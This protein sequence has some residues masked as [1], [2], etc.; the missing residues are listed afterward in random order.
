MTPTIPRTQRSLSIVASLILG[1]LGIVSLNEHLW[2]SLAVLAVG[3][4]LFWT[5][6]AVSLSAWK[7]V[8]KPKDYDGAF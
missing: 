8:R 1:Y 3:S 5:T 4:L 6:C 2:A 7:S